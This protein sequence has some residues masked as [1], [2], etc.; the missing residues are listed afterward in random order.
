[1]KR[2]EKGDRKKKTDGR[3]KREEMSVNHCII[4]DDWVW[5]RPNRNP[6]L[7]KPANSDNWGMIKS[8]WLFKMGRVLQFCL[9]FLSYPCF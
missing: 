4:A 9:Y 7:I 1:M 8:F 2:K 3:K 6:L 5:T